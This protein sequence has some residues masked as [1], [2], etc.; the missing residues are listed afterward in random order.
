MRSRPSTR[1]F[2]R[3]DMAEVGADAI[4]ALETNLRG[5]VAEN[6]SIDGTLRLW[7]QIEQRLS[8]VPTNWRFDM[9]L[10]RAY[11]DAYTRHRKIY[12][13]DLEK[14]ALARLGQPSRSASPR[15]SARLARFSSER[16][17]NTRTPNG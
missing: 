17:P 4:L 2:F 11:Y 8:G 9:H 16:R 15:P 10:F 13:N 12:E 5:S 7:Q 6:G 14:Q 3:P 1:F